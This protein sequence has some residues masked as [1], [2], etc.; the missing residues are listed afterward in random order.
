MFPQTDSFIF[1]HSSDAAL[2]AYVYVQKG[3]TVVYNKGNK[4]SDLR[5]R[6]NKNDETS[7]GSWVSGEACGFSTSKYC[8]IGVCGITN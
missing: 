7:N 2:K 4:L 5:G 8:C 1:E 6:N 3:G